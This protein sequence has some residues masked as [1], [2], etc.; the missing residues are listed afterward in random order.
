MRDGEEPRTV[1]PLVASH[2]D[3]EVPMSG[4]EW[5][6]GQAAGHVVLGAEIYADYAS[7]ATFRVI[8]SRGCWPYT[9]GLVGNSSSARSG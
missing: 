5:T 8:R 3:L 9:A 2:S 4:S 1:T 7:I 6:V